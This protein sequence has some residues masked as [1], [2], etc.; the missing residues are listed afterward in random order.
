MTTRL[1]HWSNFISLEVFLVDSYQERRY[2]IKIIQYFKP[3]WNKLMSVRF[4]LFD[5]YNKKIISK[6]YK[7][8]AMLAQILADIQCW[9]L[10]F[11][12]N[13]SVTFNFGSND[14]QHLIL[15]F[16]PWSFSRHSM[17]AEIDFDIQREKY[18]FVK[19]CS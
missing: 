6:K 10:N 7:Q 19:S 13:T 5:Y 4:V 17:L 3:L 12:L 16:F 9:L 11:C 8:H 14:S 18:L 15:A 1:F 2:L